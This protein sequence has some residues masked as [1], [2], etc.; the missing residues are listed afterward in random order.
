MLSSTALWG[1]SAGG[2]EDLR[3]L[4][5]SGEFRHGLHPQLGGCDASPPSAL[6]YLSALQSACP[7]ASRSRELPLWFLIAHK[8]GWSYLF[9]RSARP[10]ESHWFFSKAVLIDANDFCR[11]DADLFTASL[12]TIEPLKPV[13]P[14]C[15]DPI[16]L[17]R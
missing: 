11:E 15:S 8:Q 5:E 1:T 7:R 6:G 10:A 13:R 4:P 16:T 12:R 17:T 3:F 14:A 2:W 9:V